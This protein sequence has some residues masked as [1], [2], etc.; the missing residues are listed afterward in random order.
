[1]KDGP[2]VHTKDA[3]IHPQ[4]DDIK[5]HLEEDHLV[6]PLMQEDDLQ[7]LTSDHAVLRTQGKDLQALE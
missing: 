5:V 6:V 2:Q 3:D 7:A 1:M 4:Q